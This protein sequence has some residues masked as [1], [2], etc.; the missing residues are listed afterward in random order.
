MAVG[1]SEFRVAVVCGVPLWS[2]SLLC[3]SGRD[4]NFG[5]LVVK[6]RERV[7]ERAGV[8][9]RMSLPVCLLYQHGVYAWV[10]YLS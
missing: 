8:N 5:G 2:R 3:A 7:T 1:V 6:C 10:L 4:G 9:P